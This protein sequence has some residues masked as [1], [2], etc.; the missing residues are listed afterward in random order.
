MITPL[1]E[2]E[3]GLCASRAIVCLF[4]LY[5]LVFVVFLFLLVSGLAVVCD[6]GTPWTFQLKTCLPK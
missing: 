3:A 5:V 6:C 2:E 4:V 1:G